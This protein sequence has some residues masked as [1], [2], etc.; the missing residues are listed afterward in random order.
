MKRVAGLPATFFQL[1]DSNPQ[2]ICSIQG[3][4][5]DAQNSAHPVRIFIVMGFFWNLLRK[6]LDLAKIYEQSEEK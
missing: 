2:E 1:S 4:G 6:Q 5:E 3:A